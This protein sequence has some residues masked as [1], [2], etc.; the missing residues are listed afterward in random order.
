MFKINSKYKKY[1]YDF[2][3]SKLLDFLIQKR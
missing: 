3:K 2:E 1:K